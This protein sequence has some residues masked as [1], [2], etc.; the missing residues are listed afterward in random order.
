MLLEQWKKKREKVIN[1][2]ITVLREIPI[3]QLDKY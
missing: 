1:Y 2:Y 3:I